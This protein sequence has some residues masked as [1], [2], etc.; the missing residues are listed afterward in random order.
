MRLRPE[1]QTLLCWPLKSTIKTGS[2]RRLSI[3]VGLC[4]INFGFG[5][6]GRYLKRSIC[7]EKLG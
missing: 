1:I 4:E 7:F 6:G 2:C 3:D 5:L